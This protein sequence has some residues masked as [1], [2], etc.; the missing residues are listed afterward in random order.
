MHLFKTR[1]CDRAFL[2]SCFQQLRF[3]MWWKVEEEIIKTCW[4]FIGL[5]QLSNT[6]STCSP[7]ISQEGL[8]RFT[9]I[10]IVT[11]REFWIHFV[12]WSV[13]TRLK[14]WRFIFQRLSCYLCYA[15]Q[16]FCPKCR[17]VCPTF[18]LVLMK[19][20]KGQR[21][22]QVEVTICVTDSDDKKIEIAFN[23]VR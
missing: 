21:R 4:K 3:V 8:Q 15:A 9:W 2:D 1:A 20:H 17:K 12:P 16:W 23:F 7:P 18:P 10:L 22:S 6:A 5:A 19:Y 11:A 14:Y 13:K